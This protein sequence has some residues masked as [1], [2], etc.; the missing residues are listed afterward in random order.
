MKKLLNLKV[1]LT[2][3]GSVILLA[4]PA[5][6]L[7]AKPVQTGP[8]KGGSG[9]GSTGST[10][11]VLTGNDVSWPQCSKSLPKG[12]LFGIVG[13][14]DGLANTTNPC[15]ATELAWANASVGGTGQDKA[16]VYVNTA[17][18]G[19]GVADWPTSGSSTKYG[20]CT[21]GNTTACAYQYGWNMATADAQTRIGTNNPANFKW[22]LDVETD[23]SWETGSTGITNNVAD[24]EGM[25]DYFQSVGGR[26]GLYST[27]SQWKAIAGTVS[28]TSSLHG[29]DSWLPGYSKLTAA[30]NACSV[31]GLTGGKTTVT[32]Y[33][34]KQLDYDY[35]CI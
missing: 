34:S 3:L 15:F 17:D 1:S 26:V 35:S 6:A 27:A 29:L 32:Q 25:T 9:G 22:W 21:G 5:T 20:S 8:S 11:S 10:S 12:Q 28:T 14:N 19:T 7:A 24:L 13:V 18:P 31:A 4:T 2:V 16:A 30:K 23:N 33:V